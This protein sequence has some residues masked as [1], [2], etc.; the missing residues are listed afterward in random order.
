MDDGREFHIQA[1]S[2]F[3]LLSMKHAVGVVIEW[4]YTSSVDQYRVISAQFLVNFVEFLTAS[5]L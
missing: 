3:L 5:P 1:E 2:A 4:N